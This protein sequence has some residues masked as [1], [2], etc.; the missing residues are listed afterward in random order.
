MKRKP[1]LPR[2]GNQKGVT[3]VLVAIS[4]VAL[5]GFAAIAVDLAYLYI[6]KGELQNAADSGALAGAQVLYIN[7]GTQVNPGAN[8]AAA[9]FVTANYS[10]QSPVSIKLIGPGFP[11]GGIERGHWS[12]ATRHIHTQRF[13]NTRKSL[14]CYLC[15]I[16]CGSELHQRRQGDH[17]KKNRGWNR[18]AG[19]AF[20]R[21][22]LRQPGQ[23]LEAV[24]VAYIGFAGT[25]P[26][27]KPICR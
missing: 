19:R 2:L 24:A 12:F 22:D 16:G 13:H 18:L 26:G 25:D 1:L 14:E 27:L 15:A 20:F 17:Y 5:I 8:Q 9:D 21:P 11:I 7:N 4:L 10:E 3:I 6:V 23:P